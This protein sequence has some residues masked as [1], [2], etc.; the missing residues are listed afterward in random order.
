VQ[1]GN[2]ELVKL[3]TAV[4]ALKAQ[5]PGLPAL[6]VVEITADENGFAL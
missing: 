2:G 6:L 4:A 5:V 1:R 3:S